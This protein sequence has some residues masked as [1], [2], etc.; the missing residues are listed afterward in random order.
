MVKR[1]KV[2][3]LGLVETKVKLENLVRIQAAMVPR[4]GIVHNYSSHK[5]GRIWLCWDLGKV[6]VEAIHIRE[7]MI[8]CKVTS[9]YGGGS[10]ILSIVYG[11]TQGSDRRRLFHGMTFIKGLVSQ[12]SWLITGAFNVVKAPQEKSGIA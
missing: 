4:W 7:Q 1:L 11:A 12:F 6:S 2:S 3:I 10:W 8:T 9:T 5:L